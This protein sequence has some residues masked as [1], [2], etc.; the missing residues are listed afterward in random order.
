MKKLR[1]YHGSNIAFT[2]VDLSKSRDKRDFGRGFYMTTFQ[3]QAE[4]W[5]KTLHYRYGGDGIFLYTFEF[6][7][8]AEINVKVFDSLTLDWLELV[9]EN[10]V[11]GGISHNFDAVIGPVANDNIMP[12]I[13]LY[14]DGT[15]RAETALVELAYFKPN[16][17]VSIHTARALKV[18]TLIE[19]KTE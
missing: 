19:R 10:R 1:L 4:Q 3:E 18:L 15:L 17:Q 7:L 14:V 16:D 2:E 11:N 5:A 9:K 6:A 12:T 8:T 13:A